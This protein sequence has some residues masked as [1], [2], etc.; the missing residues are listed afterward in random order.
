MYSC[1]SL[2]RIGS[3][4]SFVRKYTRATLYALKKESDHKSHSLGDRTK[5]LLYV[6]YYELGIFLEGTIPKHPVSNSSMFMSCLHPPILCCSVRF[7]CSLGAPP[8]SCTPTHSTLINGDL[9]SPHRPRSMTFPPFTFK[10]NIPRCT[11]ARKKNTTEYTRIIGNTKQWR[12]DV[13]EYRHCII[14]HLHDQI[15]RDAIVH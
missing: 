12:Y 13:Q 10:H 15:Y 3:H 8:P 14:Y 11:A 2:K 1:G 4:D 9:H 5:W 6:S 7:Y